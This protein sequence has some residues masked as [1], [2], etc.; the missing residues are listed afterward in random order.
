MATQNTT[1]S[2]H[3]HHYILT[4]GN[5]GLGSVTTGGTI[6]PHPGKSRA[7]VFQALVSQVHEMH[8]TTAQWCVLFFSLEPNQI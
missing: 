4:L 1:Q 5:P 3:T 2:E 8:P 6:T 7:E